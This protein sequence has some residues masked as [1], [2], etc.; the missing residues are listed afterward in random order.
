MFHTAMFGCL[1]KTGVIAQLPFASPN[2][3]L[4]PCILLSNLFSD[5]LS[6]H[7]FIPVK[8]RFTSIQRGGIWAN[9]I[10]YNTLQKTQY[11]N[12]HIL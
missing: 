7:S 6:L 1:L 3:H 4:G 10:M 2:F 5:I 11:K 12:I 9:E 8:P